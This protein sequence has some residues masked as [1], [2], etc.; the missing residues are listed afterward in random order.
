M[1]WRFFLPLEG[2]CHTI[3]E[4]VLAFCQ[5]YNEKTNRSI[6]NAEVK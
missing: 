2:F 1:N 4:F 3:Q 6:R 5:V